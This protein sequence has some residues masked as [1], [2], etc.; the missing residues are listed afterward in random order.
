M[1]DEGMSM[2][3]CEI[4]GKESDTLYPVRLKYTLRAY[5]LCYGCL[6]ERVDIHDC[7]KP[8]REE[9]GVGVE[10]QPKLIAIGLLEDN[11]Y[12]PRMVMEGESLEQLAETIRSQG[13]Q[14]VLVARPHPRQA[15]MYQL[16]AGHH[17]REAARGAGLHSLP[18]I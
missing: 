10:G 17:R 3:R 2:L 11:P 6:A 13:F 18:V 7:G 4:C 12:Q 8:E 14:G 16:T 1:K 9:E 15:G 5:R